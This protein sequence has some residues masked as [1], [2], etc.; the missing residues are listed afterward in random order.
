MTF[1]PCFRSQIK[2]QLEPGACAVLWLCRDNRTKAP[3]CSFESP[4]PFADP[5]RPELVA[6]LSEAWIH[7]DEYIF[8]DPRFTQIL[9]IVLSE[10]MLRCIMERAIRAT[11]NDVSFC[12]PKVYCVLLWSGAS[13]MCSNH[14]C[15]GLSTWEFRTAKSALVFRSSFSL[16]GDSALHRRALLSFGSD[17]SVCRW[18]IGSDN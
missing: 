11:F 8:M 14:A 12:L 4:K 10:D 5:I 2:H 18:K 9:C 13:L 15:R 7:S 6:E 17:S 1:I 16:N 3:K